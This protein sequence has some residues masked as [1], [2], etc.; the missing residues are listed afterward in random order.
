MIVVKT[1]E[2]IEEVSMTQKDADQWVPI[3]ERDV[4]VRI[5]GQ[6]FVLINKTDGARVRRDEKRINPLV[7]LD[8]AVITDLTSRGAYTIGPH[9]QRPPSRKPPT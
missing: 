2:F 8:S 6:E 9:R 7:T 1:I 5:E 3:E 4:I